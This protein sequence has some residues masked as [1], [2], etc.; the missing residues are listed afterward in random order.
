MTAE[1]TREQRDELR[2][3]HRLD[4]ATRARCW[5]VLCGVWPCSTSRL[6]DALD[7]AEARNAELEAAN[8]RR[9]IEDAHVNSGRWEHFHN[10]GECPSCLARIAE[11][12][13]ER[14][15]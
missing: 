12:E 1:L 6:L 13:A 7:A 10:F 2:K 3:L 11:L 4:E 14:G 5:A 8:K 9:D 15:K